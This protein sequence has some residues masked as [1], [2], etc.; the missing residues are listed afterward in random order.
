[1][2]DDVL[3]ELGLQLHQF[4]DDRLVAFDDA[5]LRLGSPDPADDVGALLAGDVHAV[6]HLYHR[7]VGG[8]SILPGSGNRVRTDSLDFQDGVVGG[9][10]VGRKAHPVD[11]GVPE[12]PAFEDLDTTGLGEP[13]G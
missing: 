8:L 12:H 2:V 4:F 5:Q 6:V 1:E 11:G 7:A 3:P 9:K 10:P 13:V